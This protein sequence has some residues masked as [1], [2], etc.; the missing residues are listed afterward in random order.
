MRVHRSLLAAAEKILLVRMAAALPRW[1]SPDQLTALGVVGALVVF[2]GYVLS[3]RN[4]DFLWLANLGLVLHW[5]GDSLDGTLAR[6][7]GTERVKYGFLLDQ[8]TDVASD[9]LIMAGLGLSPYA[10][11]DSALLAL[12]GYH[13][14]TIHSLVWNAVAGEHRI[15]GAVF[16]PTELR[17]A[18]VAIN[19]ALWSGGAP[20]GFLGYAGLSWCDVLMLAVFA[21][22][23][24]VFLFSV[25][26]DA[27]ALR[28]TRKDVNRDQRP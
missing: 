7:R 17:I 11:L 24:I 15:S 22:M 21:I 14:L 20:K 25:F 9:I 3:H 5:F 13:A 6:V 8:S 10:R 18:L 23:M 12:I 16:G 27:S 2:A 1:V 4:P 19:I 26:A 28:G